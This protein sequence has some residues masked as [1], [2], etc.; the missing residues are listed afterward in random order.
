MT[1]LRLQAPGSKSQTQRAL[2]LAALARG[3]SVIRGALE[4]GDS[5]HLSGAL[6]ALGAVIQQGPDEGLTVDGFG[7]TPAHPGGALDC[8]EGGTTLRFVAPL[9]LLLADP[10]RL[11][12][13]GRLVRRPMTELLDALDMLGVQADLPGGGAVLP[14]T[15]TRRGEAGSEATVDGSRSSQFISALL[16]SGPCLPGGLEL[17]VTGER[18]SEPYLQMTLDMM[19][20]SGVTV[21]RDGERLSVPRGPYHAREMAVEGDWSGGAFL[22]AAGFITGREVQVPN[23]NP[24]SVQGDRAFA[25]HLEQLRGPAPREFSLLHCPDLV[26]PLAAACAFAPGRSEIVDVAHARHKES[27]RLAVLARG[28][29]AAGVAVTERDDGLVITGAADPDLRP[30]RLDPAQDHRMAMA[31]GL[32]SLRQ[33]EVQVLDPGCVDKSYPAFWDDLKRLGAP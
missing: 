4:C 12:G 30:A 19:A 32:L 33:P 16:L 9:S 25:A 28:L 11:E 20:A 23:L 10:L 29:Q 14:L 8:G 26:A 22:L 6:R 21:G 13:R 7:A 31:F 1:P 15:L 27:D 2:M 3:R 18:V 5:R 24:D 17:R